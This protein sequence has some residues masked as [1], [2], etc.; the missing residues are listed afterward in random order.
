MILKKLINLLRRLKTMK[1]AGKV[2]WYNP[3]KGYGFIAPD[4]GKGDVFIHRSALEAA[5][6]NDL[7]DNQKIEFE[8]IEKQ[9][10]QSAENISLMH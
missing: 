1:Q 6:L 5:G 2:K 10:K 4:N 7:S 8:V 9:G 3:E